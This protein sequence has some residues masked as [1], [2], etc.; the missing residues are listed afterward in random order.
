MSDL[1]HYDN[2]VWKFMGRIA[3]LF[4]L[5]LLWTLFSLPVVTI[6]ASSSALYY[7][8]LKMAE[9]HD[10]SIVMAYVKAFRDNFTFSLPVWLILLSVG[11]ILGADY[12]VLIRAGSPEAK[13]FFW[14]LLFPALL[15]LLMLTLIF[16]LE[17][18]L[19]TDRRHLFAM[20]FM[21]GVKNISWVFFMLVIT[22][23]VTALG[24]FVFWPLLLIG[25]GLT[26]YL[27]SQILVR[28]VF[29]R[30]GWN[31]PEP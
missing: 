16:P 11:G 4:L 31:E 14:I 29:P 25:T 8:T 13:V 12:A 22:L 19:D 1:F 23:C 5:T 15:Y 3:D 17:A 27:H 7:V 9:N 21:V 6:G 2:P 20:A 24:V 30:Y 18:R 10:D 26:A 28:A